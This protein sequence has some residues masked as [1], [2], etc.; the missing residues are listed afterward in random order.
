MRLVPIVVV[1]TALGASSGVATASPE[2]A[3]GAA[4]LELMPRRDLMSE[5]PAEKDLPYYR[6]AM[7]AQVAVGNEAGLDVGV[8]AAG[9][10]SGLGCDVVNVSAQGRV[11]PLDERV[12]G[13][14]GWALCLSQIGL[15]FAMSG[16]EEHDVAPSLDGHRS[17]WRRHYDASYQGVT[18]GGGEI[19]RGDERHRDAFLMITL[20]RTVT[21]QRDD[22]LTRKTT[23]LDLDVAVYRYHFAG[24]TTDLSVDVLGLSGNGLKAG[25]D[26]RGGVT[27]MIEPVRVRL[28]AG[29]WFGSARAGWG[30]TG[31][32][33]S[34]SSTTEVDGEVVDHWEET[35][36][37]AG[38][39]TV[40]AAVG[41][42]TVGVRTDA[43]TASVA[44][45]RLMYPTF[46]GD[47]SLEDRATAR[48]DGAIG[49]TAYTLVPF[50]TRTRSWTRARGALDE[51]S[52]GASLTVG[53]PVTELVR[54]D[55]L[56]SFGLTPYAS[57]D[58]GRVPVPVLGGDVML[59][60]TARHAR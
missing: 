41:E 56:G 35:V 2:L 60:L 23:Q 45:S 14:A 9:A 30:Q 7:F 58:G 22:A 16:Y 42:V 52:L 32:Q 38:L 48:F 31:G 40:S 12:S 1:I 49:E 46:D 4:Q 15:T 39:P 11:K 37:G 54:V 8:G 6:T 10:V 5:D 27:S 44:V 59:T 34:A 19:P 51:R 29:A 25:D 17:L 43:L 33:I 53:H 18:V 24:R 50:A 3:L 55:L 57:L 13:A 36:D 20:G 47:V 26:D 28:D 21:T